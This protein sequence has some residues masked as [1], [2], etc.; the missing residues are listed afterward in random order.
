MTVPDDLAGWEPDPDAPPAEVV[1]ADPDPV[2]DVVSVDTPPGP[3]SLLDAFA[4]K[5]AAEA[6]GLL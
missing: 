4:R 5:R 6:A 1:V 2:P 3:P